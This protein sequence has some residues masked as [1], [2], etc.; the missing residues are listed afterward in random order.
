MT[1]MF[2]QLQQKYVEQRESLL[3]IRFDVIR[4]LHSLFKS[5]VQL[6]LQYEPKVQYVYRGLY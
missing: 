5:N 6:T 3:G 2:M 1:N 4:V